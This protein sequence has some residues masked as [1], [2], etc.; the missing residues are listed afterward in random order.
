MPDKLTDNDIKK[1]LECCA[2]DKPCYENQCPFYKNACDN[3][4]HALEKYALDLIN[5]LESRIGIFSI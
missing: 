5:R 1:A 4:L 3:D 2:N